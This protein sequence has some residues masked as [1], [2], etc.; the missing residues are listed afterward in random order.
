MNLRKLH[1][2]PI[3]VRIVYCCV[4]TL[5][6]YV[7]SSSHSLASTSFGNDR[8]EYRWFS[9]SHVYVAMSLSTSEVD[10]KRRS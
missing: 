1:R 2:I 4:M 8:L 6:Y 3:A 5:F 10:G 9:D 7:A